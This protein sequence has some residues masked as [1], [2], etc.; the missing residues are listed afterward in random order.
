M[1]IY[2]LYHGGHLPIAIVHKMTIHPNE[3]A[4]LLVGNSFERQIGAAMDLSRFHELF[5]KVILYKALYGMFIDKEQTE[6]EREIC[7]EYDK[8]F[9]SE[10]INLEEY[11]HIY[12]LRD[13]QDS[14][15]IYL[16]IKKIKWFVIEEAVD[17]FEKFNNNPMG[18]YRS[19]LY[20]SKGYIDSL[21]HRDIFQVYLNPLITP[22]KV[23]EFNHITKIFE[24]TEEEKKNILYMY[25]ITE[26]T[27]KNNILFLPSSIEFL[28]NPSMKKIPSYKKYFYDRKNGYFTSNAVILDFTPNVDLNFDIKPHPSIPQTLKNESDI[29]QYPR[30]FPAEFL[31]FC[32]DMKY[33]MILGHSST[34]VEYLSTL[35]NIPNVVSY[36]T[37]F[38]RQVHLFFKLYAAYLICNTL[39]SDEFY[40]FGISESI[41]YDIINYVN[42]DFNPT[43]KY[44]PLTDL[45]EN[46]SFTIID[47]ASY[48]KSDYRALIR[49]Y[50]QNSDPED[51]IIIINSKKDFS[52]V[53]ENN[54]FIDFLV[55]I[56]ITKKVTSNLA[57]GNFE[58]EN[59]YLFSKSF[60]IREKAKTFSY[61]RDLK[62]LGIEL[63]ICSAT[64][65]E[66]H[67]E[68]QELILRQITLKQNNLIKRSPINK[69]YQL[70]LQELDIYPDGI[71]IA[72]IR[73]VNK[74]FPK[75]SKKREKIKKIAK[76]FIKVK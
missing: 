65:I 10:N 70:R 74:L 31:P 56:I 32:T 2:A 5:T 60:T 24:L 36:S 57:V 9:D 61:K 71:M 54:N 38:G 44:F 75:G 66:L 72:F 18:I 22:I 26:T 28:A 64:D 37:T 48:R 29:F 34:S 33:N 39:F 27:I 21:Y 8:L 12:N 16:S 55:P 58:N 51:V 53:S 49:D 52:F 59:I 14:F 19:N 45:S 4:V 11:S 73:L 69:N 15:G 43:D 41:F 62:N 1:I 25:G 50:I 40:S 3:D 63:T 13:V 23:D 76:I 17:G 6:V 67:G 30:Y 7:D 20:T 47:N 35:L 46:H 68:K 42:I